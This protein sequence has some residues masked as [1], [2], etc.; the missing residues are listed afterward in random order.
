MY[1]ELKEAAMK[2]ALRSGKKFGI[3]KFYHEEQRCFV[4]WF[5]TATFVFGV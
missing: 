5:R 2:A 3:A 4:V 1:G